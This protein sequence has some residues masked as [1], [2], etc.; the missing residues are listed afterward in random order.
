M[1]QQTISTGFEILFPRA[2]VKPSYFTP[3]ELASL[4]PH[5]VPSHVAIIPDGNRRWAKKHNAAAIKGHTKGAD[6]LMD[7]VKS[8]K[9]LGIKTITFYLFSTENWARNPMEVQ[10]LLWLLDSY[11]HEQCQN[12]IDHG[13]RLHTIGDTSRFS[14]K[15]KASLELTKART[16]GCQEIDFVM[17]LNY[18]ARDELCRA[19]KAILKDYK[20]HKISEKEICEELITN[21]LDT[22]EWPDPDLLIRTSGEQRLSN[23]LLWQ[24]SYSEFYTS[25]ALWPEFTPSHLL[26]A[27]L[28]FQ[29]RERRLG[30]A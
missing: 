13:I 17:A 25:D 28:H 26:K 23:F 9:Q 24:T 15:I 6:I 3:E 11:L 12:M 7:I 4:D 29:K 22:A 1:S 5:F 2:V 16:V 30:G 14:A 10:A 18:G 8:A 20:Q 19:F 27:V 21:Y